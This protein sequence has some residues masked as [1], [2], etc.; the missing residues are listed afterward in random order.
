MD[1]PSPQ[2]AQA[3][4]SRPRWHFAGTTAAIMHGDVGH[5]SSPIP[6]MLHT[7]SSNA[8]WVIT[9]AL[10]VAA[11]CVAGHRRASADLLEHARCC[12]P[13]RSVPPIVGSVGSLRLLLRTVP[14]IVGRGAS[15][16]GHG[17]GPARASPCCVTS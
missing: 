6:G 15:R 8:A 1:A 4:L 12:M 13:A 10:L 2:P 9:A 7:S 11:V 17:H 16:H 5:R 3:A 14:M